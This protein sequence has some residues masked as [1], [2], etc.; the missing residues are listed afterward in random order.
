[1]YRIEFTKAA[2]KEFAAAPARVQRAVE[3]KLTA[4][5]RDPFSPNNNV[6]ALQGENAYRLRVGD[7]R[8]VYT[9]DGGVLLLTVVRMA[10]RDKVYR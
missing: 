6:K 10:R 2:A 8:V 4:L 9:I 1:M 7:W 5:A 3:A